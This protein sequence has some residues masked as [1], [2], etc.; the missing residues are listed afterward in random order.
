MTVTFFSIRLK[1]SYGLLC[2]NFFPEKMNLMFS[3]T[4][5]QH[6]ETNLKANVAG[7]SL[8]FSFHDEDELHTSDLSCYQEKIDSYLHFLDLECSNIQLKLQVEILTIY[9]V[10]FLYQF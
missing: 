8:I 9:I 4:E 10:L 1:A 3:Y 7:I 2:I 5:Q 6:V